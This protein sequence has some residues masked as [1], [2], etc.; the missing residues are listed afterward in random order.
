MNAQTI[1]LLQEI[2][3]RESRS[4]LTYVG[5]AFPWT[6]SRGADALAWLKQIVASHNEAVVKLGRYLTKLRQPIGYLGS[7][8][9]NFTTLNFLSL[10]HI[11]PKLIESERAGLAALVN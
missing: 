7:Y 1:G 9:S 2:V 10:D 5:E 8:P 11:L 6:K 3:R 4:L